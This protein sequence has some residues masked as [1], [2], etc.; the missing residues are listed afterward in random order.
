[1]PCPIAEPV[2][3][4]LSEALSE[5]H[6]FPSSTFQFTFRQPGCAVFAYT[7]RRLAAIQVGEVIVFDYLPLPGW[8]GR[9]EEWRTRRGIRH[10]AIRDGGVQ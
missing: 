5:I 4:F 6:P 7:G 1:M 2:S 10:R 8:E 9:I 3:R